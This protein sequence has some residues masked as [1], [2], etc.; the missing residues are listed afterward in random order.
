MFP[1]IAGRQKC[2]FD[3]AAGVACQVALDL[4]EQQRVPACIALAP[5]IMQLDDVVEQRAF[6][7]PFG[8]HGRQPAR[9]RK[10]LVELRPGN[11]AAERMDTVA[12]TLGV[13][14]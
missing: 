3:K 8:V 4:V 7:P 12:R 6:D 1:K 13:L 14:V 11:R 2:T 9:A 10:H 5:A